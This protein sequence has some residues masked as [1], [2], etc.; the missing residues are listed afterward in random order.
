MSVEIDALLDAQHRLM[1]AAEA[2]DPTTVD[3]L[4]LRVQVAQQYVADRQAA[5]ET[6]N[7]EWQS[8]LDRSSQALERAVDMGVSRAHKMNTVRRNV[9]VYLT[10][11]KAYDYLY[12]LL[13]IARAEEARS[14]RWK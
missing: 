12:F 5:E 11:A 3:L 9:F 8:F 13:T 10:V 2:L 6:Q 14:R 1:R 7:A 4:A